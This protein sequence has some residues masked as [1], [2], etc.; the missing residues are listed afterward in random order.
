ME[1]LNPLKN[2]IHS[3]DDIYEQIGRIVDVSAQWENEFRELL[4]KANIKCSSNSTPGLNK[5]CN[6]LYL[7]G[8]IDEYE[9]ECLTKVI[10]RR[11]FM[12]HEFFNEIRTNPI[13]FERIEEALNGTFYVINEA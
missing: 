10:D 6:K 12:V 3:F 2:E 7:A 1:Y 13:E 8:I 11:N 5:M 4:A 9:H